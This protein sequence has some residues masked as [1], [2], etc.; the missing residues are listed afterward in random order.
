[1]ERL[2]ATAALRIRDLE[3]TEYQLR[4]SLSIC[5]AELEMLRQ[6]TSPNTQTFH[7]THHRAPSL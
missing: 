2:Q 1:M 5:Q 4:R 6:S 3:I 7:F